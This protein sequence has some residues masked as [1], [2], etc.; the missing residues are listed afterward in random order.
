MRVLGLIPARGGSKGVPR[1]NVKLLAGKPLIGYSIEAALQ[2]K[3]IDA[4]IVSTEDAEIASVAR[5][6][7]AE[8][9]LRPPELARDETAMPE[10]IQHVLKNRGEAFD[11]MILLQPTCPQRT[12]SDIDSAL[13]L[14]SNPE[15]Q[16]VISVVRVEDQHPARMY[17]IIDDRLQPLDP[18]L[19]G[20]RR[21]DLPP[22]Y[23]R[24]GA[25]YACRIT[26]FQNTGLLWDERP[27][28]FIMPRERSIN[29]D[30]SFDFQ[31]AEFVFSRR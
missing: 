14:F 5:E 18:E 26:H 17:E 11:V 25:I 13:E 20:A 1:K 8:V 6:F 28:P 23:H 12:A 29:I 7:G 30:D 31:L 3:A 22:V 4:C 19:L 16:S 24:N 21:Q 15:I 27:F 9:L 2:S 10:V